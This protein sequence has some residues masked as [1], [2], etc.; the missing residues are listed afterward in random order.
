MHD[1]DDELAMLRWA[2]AQWP[3]AKIAKLRQAV[4]AEREP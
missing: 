2:E 4:E 1:F 3:G